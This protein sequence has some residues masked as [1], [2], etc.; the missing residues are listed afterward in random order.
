MS[1][2]CTATFWISKKFLNNV[3]TQ[4]ASIIELIKMECSLE[5]KSNEETRY[6]GLTG[7]SLGKKHS[8]KRRGIFKSYVILSTQ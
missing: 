4:V 8:V 1:R 2:F 5:R 3:G 6:W 7:P